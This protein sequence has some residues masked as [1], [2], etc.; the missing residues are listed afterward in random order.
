MTEDPQKNEPSDAENARASPAT[1]LTG[2][3]VRA[4]KNDLQEYYDATFDDGVD[5]S[6]AIKVIG[7]TVNYLIAILAKLEQP[8][9]PAV[10]EENCERCPKCNAPC[11]IEFVPIED[12]ELLKRYVYAEAQ[13][14]ENMAEAL[15]WFEDMLD[16]IA[17]EMGI[18]ITDKDKKDWAAIKTIRA[19]LQAA[20][21]TVPDD[22]PYSEILMNAW[23]D[24]P[25]NAAFEWFKGYFEK[26][27]AIAAAPKADE[28]AE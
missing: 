24:R 18:N 9:P 5:P 2:A 22:A 26:L 6:E 23:N 12:D 1:G 21:Q 27:K 7:R 11:L 19:A 16:F 20:R 28:R 8:A 15:E 17:S 10:S 3:E 13:P 4:L 14:A 25:N